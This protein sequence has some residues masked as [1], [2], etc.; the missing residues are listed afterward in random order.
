MS[1]ERVANPPYEAPQIEDR[2]RIDASLIGGIS[3]I[4]GK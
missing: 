3:G 2:V 4:P 1:D